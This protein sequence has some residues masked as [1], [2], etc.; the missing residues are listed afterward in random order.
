MTIELLYKLVTVLVALECFY[1]MYLETFATT[2]HQTAKVFGI[3]PEKLAQKEVQNLF[4]NQGIYN[5]LLGV[6]LLYGLYFQPA[7]IPVIFAY[8]ALVASYGALTVHPKILLT[9]GGLPII[10]LVLGLF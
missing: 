1:I 7:L 4:K 10:G 9:Q 8:I 3:S 5:G 6:G 2:S